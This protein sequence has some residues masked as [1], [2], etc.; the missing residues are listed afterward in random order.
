MHAQSDEEYFQSRA[1]AERQLARAASDPAVTNIHASL[2]KGYEELV[3]QERAT[4]R[5]VLHIR[6]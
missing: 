3:R 5:P 2:A 6:A 1:E 4:N